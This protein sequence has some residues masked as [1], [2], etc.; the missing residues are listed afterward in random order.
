[1]ETLKKMAPHFRPPAFPGS[2][3]LSFEGI[4]GAGKS[5]QIIQA[6]DYLEAQG[7]RVLI[8]RE[9]GGTA[10]GERLRQAILASQA[11]IHPLAEMHLFLS[12]RAQLLHEV[13]LKELANPGSVVIYDRYIDSTLAY[14]GQA[15]KL[16]MDT[17][18]KCHESFPLSLMP[19]KTF[20]L[21]ISLETSMQRQ[22]MRNAPKD[23]FESQGEE[24]YKQLIAGY[25]HAHATFPDRI[26][27]IDGNRSQEVV[28][29]DIQNHL[30]QLI[31]TRQEANELI[32]G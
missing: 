19:H 6:K 8:L 7:F 14:Q 17:V 9:P 30:A 12:S 29:E 26:I 22:K 1:M 21:D 13:T 4:E 18:L 15:R 25:H 24:F 23:Y 27:K 20:L 10:F 2:Y 16:G 32:D 5:T 28:Q 3:F 31:K 11:P